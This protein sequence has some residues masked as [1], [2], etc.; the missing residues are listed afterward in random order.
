MSS[1][2]D[3]GSRSP[4]RGLAATLLA[5]AVAA[6]VVV[7]AVI[8]GRGSGS[9]AAGT[10]R[11]ASSAGAATTR[12]AP[13][14]FDQL[15]A[16]PV[17]QAGGLAGAVLI[18]TPS[19]GFNR[20]A[21]GTM[22]LSSPPA[23]VQECLRGT[24]VAEP[25]PDSNVVRVYAPAGEKDFVIHPGKAWWYVDQTSE[26]VVLCSVDGAKLV[27]FHGGSRR[28]PD[29]PWGQI[30]GR[31]VFLRGRLLVD[32]RGR[33]VLRLRRVFDDWI[34]RQLPS[35]QVLAETNRGLRADV[36]VAGHYAGA[37]SFQPVGGDM[38]HAAGISRDGK[39]V[40]G[41]CG[42]GG[43][44]IVRDHVQQHVNDLLSS[45]DVLLSPDGRWILDHVPALG[46]GVVID[47]ATLTPR[48]RV[49]L[50]EAATLLEW[51]A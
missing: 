28:L 21:L 14:Y 47:A 16:L 27:L 9:Q 3:I 33:V 42:E 46:F 41:M 39:T 13:S 25:D 38:C 15:N 49:P 10:T 17:V 12:S 2:S 43:I 18:A 29:C 23:K 5:V 22:Q 35:G 31:L 6:G 26:G 30:D 48:Y 24:Y 4:R 20:L 44:V 8:D 45:P 37:V 32:E 50:G 1:S 34:I 19:C 36:Y 11:T 40:L 51:D 7:A